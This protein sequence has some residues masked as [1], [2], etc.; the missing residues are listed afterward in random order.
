[1]HTLRLLKNLLV[2][3]QNS[4][5]V[6]NKCCFLKINREMPL[7]SVEFNSLERSE[8]DLSGRYLSSMVELTILP[9]ARVESK[10][11]DRR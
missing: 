1:M 2:I 5:R 9:Q 6:S 3:I 10:I 4:Q 11:V 8:G 7:D